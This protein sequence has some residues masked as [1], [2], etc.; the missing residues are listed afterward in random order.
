LL[1]EE[2]YRVVDQYEVTTYA[3]MS[4]K[5]EAQNLARLLTEYIAPAKVVTHRLFKSASEFIEMS[6]SNYG[7]AMRRVVPQDR[8]RKVVNSDDVNGEFGETAGTGW[9]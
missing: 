5:T 9:R 1:Y 8:Y 6:D 3:I 7:K 2:I 4:S